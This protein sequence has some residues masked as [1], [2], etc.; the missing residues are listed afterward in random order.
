V[1]TLGHELDPK[2]GTL[3]LHPAKLEALVEQTLFIVRK[4]R[5]TGHELES[6][7]GRWTWACLPARPAFSVFAA[8]YRF[9]HAAGPRVRW[10]WRSVDRELCNIVALAPLLFA[11][12]RADFVPLVV[13][14]DASEI[15][16]GVVRKSESPI[17]AEAAASLARIVPGIAGDDVDRELRSSAVAA[18]DWA[19]VVASRF[20]HPR[21]CAEHINGK[22]ARAL[23][24]GVKWLASRPMAL[25]SRVLMLSDSAVAVAAVAKGRSSSYV[26]NWTL[27]RLTM[28]CLVFGINV[29]LRWIP[30]GSNPAD[31]PSRNPR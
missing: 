19:T 27:R 11:R 23:L 21:S 29:Y 8:C 25:N 2:E 24:T 4:E 15:G 16:K 31:S 22:E 17:V 28:Y 30:S 3:G 26:I 6:L 9:V 5:C 7:L 14:T 10:L 12:L 18:G 1:T 13:A 20:N